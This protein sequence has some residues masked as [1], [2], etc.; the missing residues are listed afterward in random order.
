VHIPEY[1]QDFA[2]YVSRYIGRR[3]LVLPG[4]DFYLIP[5]TWGSYVPAQYFSPDRI[6]PVATVRRQFGYLSLTPAYDRRVEEIYRRLEDNELAHTDPAATFELMGRLR[7]EYLLVRNDA[8][9]RR[10]LP[11]GSPVPDPRLDVIHERLAGWGMSP[12]RS[13]GALEL[14]R[15]PKPWVRPRIFAASTGALPSMQPQPGRMET[16]GGDELS[17]RLIEVAIQTPRGDHVSVETHLPNR[18]TFQMLNPTAYR[19]RI[20]G[21]Q[22]PVLL[23][24]QESFH[25]LWRVHV[26]RKPCCATWWTAEPD[27]VWEYPHTG[28]RE[29]AS[30][31]VFLSRELIHGWMAPTIQ[32]RQHFIADGYANAWLISEDGN[33]E[34]LVEYMP[35][36]LFYIGLLVSVITVLVVL[37][38]I[39]YRPSLSRGT[40]Y[41][42]ITLAFP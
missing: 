26:V 33:Y 23:V 9:D 14:Y 28:V 2:E 34:L 4:D 17:R 18:V 35:Q 7:I 19:V 38:W 21:A 8:A 36:Q 3:I 31:L 30:G 32:E 16:L 24:L 15:V 42:P 13:F 1:W 10:V 12:E 5:Y 37:A 20:E 11:L 39:I 29:I 22:G 25:P 41:K 6:V 27:R 40:A